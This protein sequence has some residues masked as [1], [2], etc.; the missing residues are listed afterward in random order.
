[1]VH[2]TTDLP[3][4]ERKI[5]RVEFKNCVKQVETKEFF[6]LFLLVTLTALPKRVSTEAMFVL[7]KLVGSFFLF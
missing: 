4:R 5:L 1:M 7:T 2:L 3:P 6:F